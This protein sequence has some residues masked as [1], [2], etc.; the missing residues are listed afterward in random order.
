MKVIE[1][2]SDLINA[3]LE[4]NNDA[5]FY[6]LDL[7]DVR[8]KYRL[9]MQK[10]PRVTPFYA[11][12]CNDN[13]QVIKSLIEMGA[14]FDC[15]SQKE[16]AQILNH[17][18]SPEKIIYA[19]TVKQISHLKFA[20]ENGI[21]KVT[22]DCAAE[23]I[24]IHKYHPLAE[25]VLRI[26]FDAKKSYARLGIKFGCDPTIEAP[27]LIQMCKD[28][29][30]NLIGISFHVGSGAR[31]YEVYQ[32]ALK[33]A[34][35]LFNFAADIGIKMYFVDI[36]GG[37]IGSCALDPYADAI[38]K[39][40]DEHFKDL[41]VEIISEPGRYFAETAFTL[42]VQ[43]ILKKVSIDGH[44]NYYINDGIHMSFLASLIFEETLT[45]DVI[46]RSKTESVHEEKMSTVWGVTC[47]SK[48]RVIDSKMIP[49]LEMEDWLVFY[50]M[51]HYTI[52]MSSQFNGFTVGEVISM[53][54][55]ID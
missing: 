25:V 51:G 29:N 55:Y 34:R 23:L 13:D 10:I 43:V 26:R 19:N 32:N 14:G 48:D 17:K 3:R 38:N 31:E 22:F 12:K 36:G 52:T 15:A 46:R 9:W 18:V 24:K 27:E 8:S 5:A 44:I 11:V 20:A 40:I 30:M 39:G 49:E 42:A 2:I 47:N 37:F 1:V 45:F 53:E 16:I 33:S 6:L 7:E 50:R 4:V 21:A 35:Q 54:N 28:M 41:K